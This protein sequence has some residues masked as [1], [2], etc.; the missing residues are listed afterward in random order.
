MLLKEIKRTIKGLSSGKK[1]AL[2]DLLPR[3][4]DLQNQIQNNIDKLEK[5]KDKLL[6]YP[7]Q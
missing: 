7:D 6:M 5:L 3:A 1:L 4:A 2:Q